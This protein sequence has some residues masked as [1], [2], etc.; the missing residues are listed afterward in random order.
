[1]GVNKTTYFLIP[2]MYMAGCVYIFLAV[3]S[4]KYL[5]AVSC[6]PDAYQLGGVGF[7]FWLTGKL[8]SAWHPCMASMHGIFDWGRNVK[9]VQ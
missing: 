2:M 6:S 3:Q 4:V 9:K 7:G 5:A 1:M 8:G